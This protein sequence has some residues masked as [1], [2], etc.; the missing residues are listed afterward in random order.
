[1]TAIDSTCRE[2]RNIQ[3]GL[4]EEGF[5]GRRRI[6]EKGHTQIMPAP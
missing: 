3:R 4:Q 6:S 1:M 5:R 2:K